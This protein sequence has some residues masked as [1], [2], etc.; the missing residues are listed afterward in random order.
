VLAD[1]GYG[2]LV[3]SEEDTCS[4]AAPAASAALSSTTGASRAKPWTCVAFAC[5]FGRFH[6]DCA[7]DLFSA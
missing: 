2:A 6:T 4:L 5:T 3:L 1:V 7:C